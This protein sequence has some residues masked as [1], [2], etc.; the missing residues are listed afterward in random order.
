MRADIDFLVNGTDDAL[1]VNE[2]SDAL[3]QFALF[4]EH[5]KQLGDF[6]VSIRQEVEGQFLLGAKLLLRLDGVHADAQDDGVQ[7]RQFVRRVPQRLHLERSARRLGFDKKRQDDPLTFEVAQLDG[8]AILVDGFKG[9]S[10]FAHFG[11]AGRWRFPCVAHQGERCQYQP[12]DHLGHLTYVP[13]VE[14]PKTLARS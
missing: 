10:G 13:S 6:T 5:A 12:P 3:R 11:R 9:G 14:T 2:E 4:V 8:L 7:F 1:R